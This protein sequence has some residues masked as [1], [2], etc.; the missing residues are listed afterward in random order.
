[1]VLRVSDVKQKS[2]D[3]C[4]EEI[5]ILGTENDCVMTDLISGVMGWMEGRSAPTY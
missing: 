4:D 5:I 1:M 3:K 2:T